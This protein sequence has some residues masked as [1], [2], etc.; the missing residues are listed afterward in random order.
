M[1]EKLDKN[2]IS[3]VNIINIAIH[4]SIFKVKLCVR[5]IL[6]FKKNF[7]DTQIKARKLKKI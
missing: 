6:K 4:A 5:F 3:L 7:K 1:A 2:I